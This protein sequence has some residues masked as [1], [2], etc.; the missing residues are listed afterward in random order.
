MYTAASFFSGIGGID[1]AFSWTGFDI[2]LQCEIDDYCQ[3]VLKKHADTYWPHAKLRGDIKNVTRT[4]VG[5]VDVIFGGF[6]CFVAGT[7]VLTKDGYKPIETLQVGELVLTH[8]GRWQPILATM[9]RDNAS[10]R[11]VKIQSTL[12]IYTTDEHPF[13]VREYRSVWDGSKRSYKREFDTPKWADAKELTNDMMAS[14]VLPVEIED[15]MYKSAD[16]WW[17][18][19]RYL[20]DGWRVERHDRNTDGGKVIICGNHDEAEE[21]LSHIKVAGFHATEEI[22][23]TNTRY[24]ITN[25]SLYQFLEQFGKYAHGKTLPGWCLALPPNK[26]RTLILGY[27]TGDGSRYK[28]KNGIEAGWKVTT[29]SES[30]ALGIAL[31]AQHALGSV[32]SVFKFKV[33]KTTEIEGRIVNQRPQY[34]V[35]I[36]DRNRSNFIED[37]Y[38]WKK[39]STNTQLQDKATVYNIE[40]SE[41]NSYVV[42]NTC[43]HNCQDIS[44]AGKQAGVTKQTRSGL[45]FELL[46][47][48]GDVRPRVVLLENVANILNVGGVTVTS[49]LAELGYDA[50]WIPLRAADVGAPHKRERWFCVAYRKCIR[51]KRNGGSRERNIQKRPQ[52]ALSKVIR[53]AKLAYRH[54]KRRASRGSYRGKRYIQANQK[55]HVTPLQS[56]QQRFITQPRALGQDGNMGDSKSTRLEGASGTKPHRRQ[57]T[58]G[59]QGQR[60]DKRASIKSRLGRTAY[61]LSARMDRHHG[62][63]PARPNEA[64]YDYEPT[65][66]TGEKEN[67]VSRIKALGNAV[68]PQQ[69]LP[70][71]LAIK[72]FLDK[73]A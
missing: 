61:G 15:F 58:K 47:I 68:V 2:R 7:M 13:F 22:Q 65:R 36:P 67:R 66:V 48:I 28:D 41:D 39:I 70:L 71:A 40:V 3:Q 51:R 73:T 50:I 21:I 52:K 56:K 24:H 49:T 42:G 64:Q 16:F 8:T 46:R 72:D 1:L 20:A 23:R 27:L 55:R 69:V 54:G 11:E 18:V 9:K 53:K 6:P 17:L 60:R 62:Q 10:I 26:A 44:I 35:Q 63:W 29:V 14:Q 59:C 33:P 34:Q 43:V 45:W 5:Y 38:G 19:G 57:S 30:L 31:L 32:S 37:N 25:K 12:P 4:D